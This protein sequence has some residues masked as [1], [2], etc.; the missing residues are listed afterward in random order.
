M[1]CY[2]LILC[3]CNL[4]IYLVICQFLNDAFGVDER[5][6]RILRWSIG[7]IWYC[8]TIIIS[9][10]FHIPILNFL[11][12]T[13]LIFLITIGYKGKILKKIVITFMVSILSSACDI[14]AYFIMS[15]AIQKDYIFSVSYIFTVILFWVLERMISRFLVKD[16]FIP[17]KINESIVLFIIPLCSLVLLYCVTISGIGTEYLYLI[18]ICVLIICFIIF[19]IYHFFLNHI[20]DR[21]KNKIL[22][23]CLNGYINE[24]ELMKKSELKVEGMRHDLKNHLIE[25]KSLAGNGDPK[26]V[27]K[28]V[29]SMFEDLPSGKKHSRTGS[30]ELDSL[31][32]YLVE[33]EGKDLLDVNVKVT[34]PESI[35][36][37]KYK[38]NIILGNL[39]QNAIEAAK[40]S[41]NKYL[42][43]NVR[44][45]RNILIIEIENSYSNDIVFQ[46]GDLISTKKDK[47]QHVIGLRNVKRIVKE[48]NGV[49]DIKTENE[50]F[51]VK[52]MLFL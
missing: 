7:F 17:L 38:L 42:S 30:Y 52:V 12:N 20:D 21:Y 10:T 4:F 37:N 16:R 34:V 14:A 1:M 43:L 6:P 8:G 11:I 9:E 50:R 2:Y 25:L 35:E 32:N 36:I 15:S 18:G 46:K 40:A 29:D 44:Y 3:L 31:I 39:L 24:L 41:K 23:E 33:E 22:S 51:I 27:I 5:K 49:I 28:Y 13:A 45:D 26:E 48:Q 19:Y 47:E